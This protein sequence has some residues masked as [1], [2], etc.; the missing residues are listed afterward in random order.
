MQL[1]IYVD[2]Q[3][4]TGDVQLKIKIF[5]CQTLEPWKIDQGRRTEALFN[6]S[7]NCSDGASFF[8]KQYSNE[9]NNTTNI[10]LS[11]IALSNGCYSVI[12]KQEIIGLTKLH[13]W[14]IMCPHDGAM[15]SWTGRKLSLVSQK[16]AHFHYSRSRVMKK[17]W[18]CVKCKFEIFQNCDSVVLQPFTMQWL[19]LV[20]F[21]VHAGLNTLIWEFNVLFL[22]CHY[23]S[24]CVY[25]RGW[26]RGSGTITC[27]I[28]CMH[29]IYE[30]LRLLWVC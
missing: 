22:Y 6:C 16:W 13:K 26:E 17:K 20:L 4:T 2:I 11:F 29:V 21:L 7:I 30:C 1:P 10:R 15:A 18:K 19:D 25:D 3:N 24:V 27:Y 14:Y 8:G 12:I 28:I 5:F 9:E 23:V